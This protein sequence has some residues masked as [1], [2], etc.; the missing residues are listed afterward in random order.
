[1]NPFRLPENHL[2]MFKALSNTTARHLS[3]KES[4]PL[5]GSNLY[6]ALI[7]CSRLYGKGSMDWR[8]FYDMHSRYCP[9]IL[10]TTE[11][12]FK[13][14]LLKSSYALRDSCG[15]TDMACSE[16][17]PTQ[18]E[19]KTSTLRPTQDG[20][21]SED[22]L[23]IL[24]NQTKARDKV[25]SVQSTYSDTL[26]R[27]VTDKYT[28]QKQLTYEAMFIPVLNQRHTVLQIKAWCLY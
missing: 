4:V 13:G 18:Y 16:Y 7:Q 2:P 6:N 21:F 8:A 9:S 15:V 10:N 19:S 24:D 1:M 5:L 27:L 26:Y 23:T 22:S 11:A 3:K 17:L 20:L 12:H 28:N 14:A 25:K